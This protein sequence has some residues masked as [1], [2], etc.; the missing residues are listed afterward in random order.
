[1]RA[2]PTAIQDWI[3]ARL[4]AA[5]DVGVPLEDGTVITIPG[6]AATGAGADG[7]ARTTAAP[8]YVSRVPRK[9]EPRESYQ[10]I[11][12]P[13]E[14]F[15]LDRAIDGWRRTRYVWTVRREVRRHPPKAGREDTAIEGLDSMVALFE[16]AIHALRDAGIWQATDLEASPELADH[17]ESRL[18]EELGIYVTARVPVSVATPVT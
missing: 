12:E 17:D 5:R 3:V 13:E 8:V 10:V 14:P 1:M 9:P 6:A 7:K 4:E 16:Q 18:I 2:L 15:A 11:P